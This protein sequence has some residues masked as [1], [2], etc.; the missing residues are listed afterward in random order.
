[1]NILKKQ[2]NLGKTQYIKDI[3]DIDDIYFI[4]Y[5]NIVLDGD[6]RHYKGMNIFLM[7]K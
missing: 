6:F 2:L 1:M 3:R 4:K 7:N 5:L